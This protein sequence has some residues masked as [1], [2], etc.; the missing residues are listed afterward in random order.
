MFRPSLLAV[1][2]ATLAAACALGVPERGLAA[3]CGSSAYSYAGLLGKRTSHGIAATITP[4]S[5]PA[6]RRGHVAAW[7]GVGG[8]GLGPNGTTEWLQAGISA[9]PG[10][11]VALYYELTL[12]HAAPKYVMLK[13]RLDLKRSYRIAVVESP[14][15]PGWWHVSVDGSR[16]MRP[17][18]LPGSHGA[19]RPVATSESW[20]GGVGACNHFAFHFG[21]VAT[22]TAP[23]RWS[24]LEAHQLGGPGMR[25]VPRATS[26]FLATGGGLAAP[27]PEPS[28]PYTPPETSP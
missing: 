5:V 8:E 19:W 16:L 25:L 28:N 14:T 12:P 9:D 2:T 18:F 4:L 24:S 3:A 27:A 10:R 26:G 7:V 23:G 13:G 15:R 11:G 1:A 6:V 20:N 17:V 21:R 22:A